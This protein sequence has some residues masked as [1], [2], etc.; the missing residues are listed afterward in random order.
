MAIR[1]SAIMPRASDQNINLLDFGCIRV[2]RPTLVKGII[3]LYYALKDGDRDL[4][5]QR[6]RDLGLHRSQKRGD[7]HPQYLGGVHLRPV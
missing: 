1:I 2:F 6:L 4:A 3:D 5:V 7:R